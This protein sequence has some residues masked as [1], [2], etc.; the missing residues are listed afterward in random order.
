MMRKC[1]S[2]FAVRYVNIFFDDFHG[3]AHVYIQVVDTRTAF[4]LH[5]IRL[6]ARLYRK[7]R[8]FAGI[9]LHNVN[10][11][12]LP[13]SYGRV[14]VCVRHNMLPSIMPVFWFKVM[15]AV[16]GRQHAFFREDPDLQKAQ[17]RIAQIVFRMGDARS[18]RR[19]LHI[20]A[21]KRAFVSHA[22]S[23][24]QLSV[25][26]IGDDFHIAVRVRGKT[27]IGFHQVVVDYAQ[28]AEFDIFRI[29]VV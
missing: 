10:I 1:A 27:G 28:F 12:V 14:A 21:G 9:Q 5:Q 16:I 29:V 13:D 8:F 11:C 23:V 19:K 7:V 17:H 15:I 22:V 20:A 18:G 3:I 6:S 24:G 25:N 2:S 4:D 26:H